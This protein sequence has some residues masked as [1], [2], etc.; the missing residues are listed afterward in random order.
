M[1]CGYARLIRPYRVALPSVLSRLHHNCV[2]NL[3]FVSSGSCT[4]SASLRLSVGF[5][6]Q[7][8]PRVAAVTGGLSS[9]LSHN[10]MLEKFASPCPSSCKN[11]LLN[12]LPSSFSEICGYIAVLVQIGQKQQQGTLQGPRHSSSG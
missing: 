7:S 4:V 2:S 12:L 11:S 1:S 3:A 5:G 8:G 10:E 6:R 9:L